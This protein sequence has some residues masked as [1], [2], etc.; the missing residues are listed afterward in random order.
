MI[1]NVR[2]HN[3]IHIG[4]CIAMDGGYPLFLNQFKEQAIDNGYEVM[5]L[6]IVILF[7]LPEKN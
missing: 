6:K 4:S 7:V 1:L 5:N 2:L 3:K